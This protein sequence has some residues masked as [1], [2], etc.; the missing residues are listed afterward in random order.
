MIPSETE[1]IEDAIRQLSEKSIENLIK[2]LV[3]YF[4]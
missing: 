1:D 4:F 2:E 3:E